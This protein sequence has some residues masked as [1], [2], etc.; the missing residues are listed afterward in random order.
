MLPQVMGIVT[1]ENTAR[2]TSEADPE[3]VD[4]L[5]RKKVGETCTLTIMARIV[6]MSDSEVSVVIEDAIPEGYEEVEHD[7]GT[8]GEEEVPVIALGVSVDE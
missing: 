8:D 6:E 3:L 5:G 1:S 4:I 2:F 7:H